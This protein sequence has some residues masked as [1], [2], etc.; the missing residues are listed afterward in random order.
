MYTSCLILYTKQNSRL[1]V[2]AYSDIIHIQPISKHKAH[3]NEQTM[4][5]YK[6]EI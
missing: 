3:L 6:V 2:M 4:L 1:G 5:M